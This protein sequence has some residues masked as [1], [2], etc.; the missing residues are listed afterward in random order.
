MANTVITQYD[1]KGSKKLS[2]SISDYNWMCFIGL[3]WWDSK[4]GNNEPGND[5]LV[6]ETSNP[7]NAATQILQIRCDHDN[8]YVVRSIGSG[9]E[10]LSGITFDGKDIYVIRK[11]DIDPPF[12][13]DKID[14][15]GN[16]K[17]TFSVTITG[18]KMRGLTFDGRFL[19]SL[20]VDHGGSNPAKIYQID[21]ISNK[22]IKINSLV[23]KE[24]YDLTHDGKYIWVTSIFIDIDGPIVEQYYRD[25]GGYFVV[26]ERS[27]ETTGQ[28]QYPG[29]TTQGKDLIITY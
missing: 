17:K 25:K 10:V 2:H 6:L 15:L 29:I 23:N 19:Y 1:K 28:T 12:R 18:S 20:D 4:S 14:Y 22:T 5:Y 27:T 13:I 16:I 8:C 7:E 9:T 24:S 21:P 26:K 11:V 3:P